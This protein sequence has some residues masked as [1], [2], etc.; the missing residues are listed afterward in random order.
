MYI[1]MQLCRCQGVAQAFWLNGRLYVAAALTLQAW[2]MA[3]KCPVGFSH[4]TVNQNGQ[5]RTVVTEIA[6]KYSNSR[7]VF[8]LIAC[9]YGKVLTA[10]LFHL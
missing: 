8:R 6:E 5:Q 10:L 7:R 9:Q 1:Y 3:W 2:G 4:G